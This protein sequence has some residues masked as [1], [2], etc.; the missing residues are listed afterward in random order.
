M[1]SYRVQYTE[2]KPGG[3][4]V[5][6]DERV[7]GTLEDVRNYLDSRPVAGHIAPAVTEYTESDSVG[8]F[9]PAS[10]WDI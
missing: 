10:E 5:D 8:R 1:T 3:H 4:L 2:L 7:T 9:V 6:Q